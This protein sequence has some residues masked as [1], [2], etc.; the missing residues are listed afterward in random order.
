MFLPGE[1]AEIAKMSSGASSDAPLPDSTNSAG[2]TA[3]LP[4]GIG[5][6][7]MMRTASPRE[8]ERANGDPGSASPMTFNAIRLYGGRA[9]S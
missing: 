8:S 6:P 1:T 9:L 2:S 4:A 7:V 5:A 3:S